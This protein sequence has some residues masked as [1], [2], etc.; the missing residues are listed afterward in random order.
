[1]EI[2]HRINK[3]GKVKCLNNL[4]KQKNQKIRVDCYLATGID[5]ITELINFL[6][7]NICNL[8]NLNM[9]YII[10]FSDHY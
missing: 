3:A 4:V 8:I 1:M 5:I 10:F 6:I 9:L 2:L 7:M